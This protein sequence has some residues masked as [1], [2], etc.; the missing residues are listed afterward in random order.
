MGCGVRSEN[1]KAER[2]GE[3]AVKDSV[4]G[5]VWDRASKGAASPERR[6]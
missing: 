6:G 1:F 2:G 5:G 4:V 3:A